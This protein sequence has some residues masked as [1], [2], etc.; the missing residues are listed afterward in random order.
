M[1]QVGGC[2][3][4]QVQ[5]GQLARAVEQAGLQGNF[6]LEVGQ[7]LGGAVGLAG[8]DLVAGAVITKALAE[9][10]VDV[11]RQ[12][13]GHRGLVAA[14]GGLAIF[15]HGERR[16]KLRRGG[17]RRVARPWAIVFFD[18]GAIESGGSVHEGFNF[19]K[20][21]WPALSG[22]GSN[23]LQIASTLRRPAGRMPMKRLDS[24][25]NP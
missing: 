13:L 6:A 18:Q 1:G 17:I 5:L 15:V 12:R 8:D 4:A 7:V 25:I 3:A 19:S 22:A 24:S 10:D 2:A 16:V 20:E 9:R 23:R 11:H 21:F 14:L